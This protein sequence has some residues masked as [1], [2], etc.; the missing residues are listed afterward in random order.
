MI[1]RTPIAISRECRTFPYFLRVAVTQPTP[2][3]AIKN[4]IDNPAEYAANNV[5][6]TKTDPPLRDK[7]KIAP[8]TGP[9]QGDQ[10][11]EKKTP[12]RKE[13]Q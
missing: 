5:P 8:S 3:A 11:A 10:P 4:G 7:V 12:I 6:P 13:D 2:S 1:K 9:T